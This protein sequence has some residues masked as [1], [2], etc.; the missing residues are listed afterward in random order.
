MVAH[1]PRNPRRAYDAD[2]HEIRPMSLGNLREQGVRAVGDKGRE[3]SR[4]IRV[5]EVRASGATSLRQI[6]VALNE[7]RIPTAHGGTW[8]ATQVKRALDVLRPVRA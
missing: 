4:A 2:R 8:Q 7:R 1:P 3:I 5:K 6:A